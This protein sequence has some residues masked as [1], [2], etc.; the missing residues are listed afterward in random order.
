MALPAS[1]A[2]GGHSRSASHAHRPDP[3]TEGG[4][5]HKAN[6]FIRLIHMDDVICTGDGYIVLY[7]G[8]QIAFGLPQ[9]II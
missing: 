4:L 5:N 1:L 6:L 8:L 7:G 9:Q 3:G 2:F